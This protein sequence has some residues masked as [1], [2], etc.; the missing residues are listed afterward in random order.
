MCP[1]IAVLG[2]GGGGG[3]GDGSGDGG[4]EGADGKGNGKGEG[5]S[6]N[7]NGGGC[8]EGDPICPITGRMF[9]KIYDFGFAGPLPLR[10][11]RNYSSRSAGVAGEFGHGWSHDYGWRVRLRRQCAEVFD[12]DA[13]KQVFDVVP[14]PGEVVRNGLG[15]VLSREGEGLSL[16]VPREGL[17]YRFGADAGGG[18]HHLASVTDRNGNTIVIDRDARGVLRQITDSAGRPIRFAT[19]PQG[20]VVMASVPTEPTHQEWMELARYLYDDEGNLASATDAE[21]FTASY[22]YDNHLMTEHRS[23]SGLSYCYRYDGRSADACCVESWGEFIGKVDPALEKPI[24]PRPDGRDARRLKGIHHVRLTY[25]KSQRYTEVENGLG[26]VTRYFGDELGRA[27]KIVDPSGGVTERVFDP[28]TGG[29]V[30][31]QGQTDPARRVECDEGGAASGY[32]DAQGKGFVTRVDDEGTEVTFDHHHGAQIRR[33]RDARGN[34]TFIAYPDGTFEEWELDA[35]GIHTR[36]I[37]RNGGVIRYEH[38]G[39]G[40]C[41]ALHLPGGRVERMEYDYLGRR[42]AHVDASGNRTEWVWDRRSEVVLRRFPGGAERRATYD[43]NRKIVELDDRGQVTRYEYGGIGWCTRLTR[44]SGAT[45]DFRYDLMGNLVRITNPRGQT[46]RIRRDVAGA[47]VAYE[48]FEGAQHA[49]GRNVRGLASWLDGPAGRVELERDDMQRVTTM[50][51]PDGDIA[52]AYGFDGIEKVDNGMVAVTLERDALGRVVRDVQ[53]PHENRVEWAGGELAAVTSNV[54]PPVSFHYGKSGDLAAIRAGS[55]ALDLRVPTGPDLLSRLGDGLLLRQCHDENRRLVRQCLTRRS[56]DVAEALAATSADPH[57]LFWAAYEYDAAGR[58]R[59]EW[60]S[61]GRTIDNQLDADGHVTARRTWRD[62]KV[63]SEERVAYDLAGTPR[64]AGA[65]YDALARPVALHGEEIGYDAAGRLVQRR[66]DAGEWRY[67]WNALDQLVAVHAPAHRVEMDYD[68]DGRR[69]QKRVF[70]QRELVTSTSYVWTNQ[71]VLHEVDDLSGATR[72]YLRPNE[73]W[74]AL[75]HVDRT[76]GDERAVYYVLTPA[77][78]LDLAVDADGNVVWA[79][80]QTIYGHATPTTEEVR[81][82]ARFQNQSYDPDVE[83]TYNLH[84]WYDARLGV[85][86]SIDPW[87]LEGNLNPRDYAPNPFAFSDPTGAMSYGVGDG[88]DTTN[89]EGTGHHPT[90]PGK[91]GQAPP[92]TSD[93]VNPTTEGHWGTPGHKQDAKGNDIPGYAKC[94][95]D[96]DPKKDPLHNGS[97]VFGKDDDP[98]SAQGIVNAA[99]KAYGCHGCGAQ[100]SGFKDPNHW[101]CDHVPPRSTYS[102]KNHGKD[103]AKQATSDNVRLYPHC[104]NCMTNQR[105]KMSAMSKPDKLAAGQAGFKANAPKPK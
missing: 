44:A 43:A 70:R 18:W 54:G 89:D 20:R 57:V 66:T 11:L 100:T 65:R 103:V 49:M 82:S 92:K 85:Y 68:A 83:L 34:L 41:V 33:R 8:A 45:I 7:G 22:T 81:V 25:L 79:A 4:K 99:G 10:F 93:D 61:D 80:E 14:R 30:A 96:P 32:V 88:T 76:A 37:A 48:T 28:E 75:G 71:V 73:E 101:C 3:D 40:N 23:V 19:D 52:F 42:V 13:R 2:G 36:F 51:T 105:N 31:E 29:L 60:R 47:T 24:P 50:A 46:F 63:V 58:L 26:G 53:G 17:T 84:R 87:I 72:T 55:T 5:A 91:Q 38:D 16:R 94:P 67:E 90:P 78:G 97:G 62:G 69:M 6:G 39:M 74:A 102:E 86:A 104:K 56:P 27:V 1:G 12:G 98:K 35:R 9:L 64:M 59:R 95:S 15:W 77:G 21:G